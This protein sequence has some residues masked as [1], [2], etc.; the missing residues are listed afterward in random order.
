MKK[1]LLL[2]SVTS[3]L[4]GQL[5]QNTGVTLPNN[6]N[7][8]TDEDYQDM[9]Y[10][11]TSPSSLNLFKKQANNSFSLVISIPMPFSQSNLAYVGAK[12]NHVILTHALGFGASAT[13]RF[14]HINAGSTVDTIL[15]TNIT[16]ING[17][18]MILN[19]ND[20]Y[21]IGKNKIFKSN[22]TA[23][24]TSLI[25]SSTNSNTT[26]GK[27][28]ENNGYL[29]WEESNPLNNWW[30]VKKYIQGTISIVD[31]VDYNQNGRISF[32][33]DNINNVIYYAVTKWQSGGFCKLYK[34]D[35]NNVTTTL[36]NVPFSTII[37]PSNF[38]GIIGK[39]NNKLALNTMN[40]GIYIYDV[41]TGQSSIL[42]TVS[43]ATSFPQPNVAVPYNYERHQQNSNYIYFHAN[44]TASNNTRM[45]V[46]NGIILKQIAC[47]TCTNA[48]GA[49]GF[50]GMYDAMC[51][52]DLWQ[53]HIGTALVR[54]SPTGTQTAEVLPYISP[55]Y[56]NNNVSNFQIAGGKVYFRRF[57]NNFST[58]L[59]HVI[60]N[61]VSTLDLKEDNQNS[62]YFSTYP[63]PVDDILHINLSSESITSDNRIT[64]TNIL[65][66]KI[67]EESH[68]GTN[69]TINLG[70]LQAGIYLLTLTNNSKKSTQK[71][72]IE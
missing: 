62:L 15:S 57:D 35:A 9:Y 5:S 55:S 68:L 39:V 3:S 59:L 23:A 36:R 8:F 53:R 65:G 16:N 64:I 34:V 13:V 46:T 33:D 2:L 40:G 22:Y 66:E 27:V 14:F 69:N 12:N 71:I 6:I 30:Y 20:L 56:T 58:G 38:E 41:S 52:D 42:K 50:G 25:V 44:D 31:S 45:W 11:S 60:A 72:I 10:S 26:I 47:P 18:S 49:F 21:I 7:I 37:S 67:I 28:V 51:G 54:S 24:G 29:M 17:G 48:N 70:S 63:N 32:F 61:C 19:A 43:S 4:F 1:L